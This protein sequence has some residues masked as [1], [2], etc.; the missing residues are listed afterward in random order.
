[1]QLIFLD[2]IPFTCHNIFKYN[3]L[4]ILSL[5]CLFND[6]SYKFLSC[7]RSNGSCICLRL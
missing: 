4:S 2:F 5:G 1:M 6:S 7:D 3:K